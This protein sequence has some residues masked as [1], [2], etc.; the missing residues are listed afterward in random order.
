[1]CTCLY[2]LSAVQWVGNESTQ[3]SQQFRK[4]VQKPP[5]KNLKDGWKDLSY[6]EN[7]PR[8]ED[9]DNLRDHIPGNKSKWEDQLPIDALKEQGNC[10]FSRVILLKITHT[11]RII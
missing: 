11:S 8:W 4:S 3:V 9:W 1:M 6:H 2:L 7:F 10:L 5:L